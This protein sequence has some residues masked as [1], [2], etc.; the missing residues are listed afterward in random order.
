MSI[1]EKNKDVIWSNANELNHMT[2]QIP[3][4]KEDRAQISEFLVIANEESYNENL[5]KLKKYFLSVAN[6]K[7]F[8]DSLKNINEIY[9]EPQWQRWFPI[10]KTP[11]THVLH[12]SYL[13]I[14][15]PYFSFTNDPHRGLPMPE[16]FYRQQ[17]I[18]GAN[19]KYTIGKLES[20]YYIL[21]P[22]GYD[23]PD[24][25]HEGVLKFRLFDISNPRYV[26]LSRPD[27]KYKGYPTPIIKNG[28]VQPMMTDKEY[29][30]AYKKYILK[31]Q[32]K[33][34]QS[35]VEQE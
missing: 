23:F 30:V 3:L 18:L 5:L 1:L 6:S 27:S 32:M 33:A 20:F 12:A 8:M 25:I 17:N 21:K 10:E 26:N 2:Q 9:I 15:P 7:L 28:Q 19:I 4:S 31:M 29:M 22:F 13:R 34:I 35:L 24:M 16:I 14:P 11:S